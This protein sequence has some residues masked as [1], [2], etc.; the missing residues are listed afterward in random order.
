MRTARVFPSMHDLLG[1][2]TPRDG[3]A[4]PSATADDESPSVLGYEI[5]A[6]LGSGSLGDVK[7]GVCPRTGERVAIK[8]VDHAKASARQIEQSDNEVCAL[9][10]L[11]G[12][13]HCLQLKAADARTAVTPA[14]GAPAREVFAL[15]TEFA[16]YGDLF[17]LIDA[18]GAFSEPAAKAIMRQLV[19][20]LRA[21]EGRDVVAHR[22][23]KPENLLVR[24]DGRL[25]VADFNLSAHANADAARTPERER[26]R[27]AAIHRDALLHSA[28]GSRSYMAPEVLS[29][30]D[31]YLGP[32]ADVWSAA[33]VL[34]TLLVGHPPFEEAS[35]RCW[36]FRKA[37]A[38]PGK[39]HLFWAAHA[40]TAAAAAPAAAG[41]VSDAARAL[42][43]RALAAEPARRATLDELARDAWFD[44]GAPELTPAE[45]HAEF[46]RRAALVPRIRGVRDALAARKIGGESPRGVEDERYAG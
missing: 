35:R 1:Y 40:Q 4:S 34:F 14:R 20:G 30:A 37:C 23:L 38:E 13:P 24:G 26:R 7:L 28:C 27:R 46:A 43:A 32:P 2:G 17:E 22:D 3:E 18:G 36:F 21:F 15:V 41:G 25:V 19:A 12:A 44:G 31:A 42:L 45:L 6:H 29:G 11:V 8:M 5:I 9:Q 16:E 33:V 10:A 39:A